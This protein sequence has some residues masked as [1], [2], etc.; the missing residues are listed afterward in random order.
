MKKLL[1]AALLGVQGALTLAGPASACP[2]CQDLLRKR[3]VKTTLTGKLVHKIEMA[4]PDSEFPSL[5]TAIETWELHVGDK[6]YVLDLTEPMLAQARKLEGKFVNVTGTMTRNRLTV[7]KIDEVM[8]FIPLPPEILPL[9]PD[10]PPQPPEA[11]PQRRILPLVPDNILPEAAS[12][13]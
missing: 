12:P 6:V 11:G 13:R 8:A 3:D 10:V 1:L 9:L 5:P 2:V 4:F 7:E